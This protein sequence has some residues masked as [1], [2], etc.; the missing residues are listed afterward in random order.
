[1]PSADCKVGAAGT[2]AAITV[3]RRSKSADGSAQPVVVA[4]GG[5]EDLA[6]AVGKLEPR[7]DAVT[8][9]ETH[10]RNT[11]PDDVTLAQRTTMAQTRRDT[12]D[13]LQQSLGVRSPLVRPHPDCCSLLSPLVGSGVRHALR[14]CRDSQRPA[15]KTATA[16]GVARMDGYPRHLCAAGWLLCVWLGDVSAGN[17]RV[18]ERLSAGRRFTR[19]FARWRLRDGGLVGLRT[20]RHQGRYSQRP[21]TESLLRHS[22]RDIARGYRQLAD[23]VADAQ[24][25][26]QRHEPPRRERW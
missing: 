22:W 23:F 10:V 12:D 17:R 13:Q 4:G 20:A 2:S 16:P 8:Y 1:M 5:V 18:T 15:C 9:R 25:V 7:R 26:R 11:S 24:A 21:H 14:F 6:I 19:R 3:A